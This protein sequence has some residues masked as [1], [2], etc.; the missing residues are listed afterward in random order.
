MENCAAT[1]RVLLYCSQI[2]PSMSAEDCTVHQ[3]SLA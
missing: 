2:T 1:A 3:D